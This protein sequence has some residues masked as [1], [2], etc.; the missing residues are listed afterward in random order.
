MRY[1]ACTINLPILRALECAS[2]NACVEWKYGQSL[3]QLFE[4]VFRE[5]LFL[6]LSVEY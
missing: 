1:V 2:K 5:N 4:K 6:V 3:D